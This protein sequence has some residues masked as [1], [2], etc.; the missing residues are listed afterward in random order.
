VRQAGDKSAQGS[1]EA[2]AL[3][4]QRYLPA[5]RAHLQYGTSL[6]ESQ[7]DD[8]L[9]G[10]VSDKILESD[11]LGRA[12]HRRGKFRTLLLTSLHRYMVDQWRSEKA[13]K[14]AAQQAVQ[15]DNDFA[16]LWIATSETA[17]SS[18]DLAWA[19]Q[20]ID[21]TLRRM[22]S[23]CRALQRLDMWGVF[24]T[25]LVG[26]ILHGE[27]PLPYDE[28]VTKFS[29]TTPRQ[30]SNVLITGK[31][32]FVRILREVVGEYTP[33]EE[34]DVEIQQLCRDLGGGSNL[35]SQQG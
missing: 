16:G 18:F 23:E 19:R 29:L 7:V 27:K 10:F 12:D 25:R 17:S 33:H 21:E 28:L 14:R 30:A 32:M 13:K 24:E 20:I 4:L 22:E 2:L 1:R 6:Q 35:I 11:L 8:L 9:Q 31:R 15:L 5:L 34:I 26:P 3:L